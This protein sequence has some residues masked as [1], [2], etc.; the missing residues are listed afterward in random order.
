MKKETCPL[1]NKVVTVRTNGRFNRHGTCEGWGVLAPSVVA[2]R[3]VR[4]QRAVDAIIGIIK[5][6][7]GLADS[8]GLTKA[9]E[10]IARGQWL[11]K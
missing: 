1:C 7:T 3:E 2:E 10:K 6:C 5:A 9:A 8:E 11:G 4:G